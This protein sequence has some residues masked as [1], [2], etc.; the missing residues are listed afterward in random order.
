[1]LAV[2]D[3]AHA[4]PLGGVDRDFP[5]TEDETEGISHTS[6]E[7]IYIYIYIHI[8]YIILDLYLL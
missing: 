3:V 7:Y 2:C 8:D 1:M 4:L 6:L 5:F